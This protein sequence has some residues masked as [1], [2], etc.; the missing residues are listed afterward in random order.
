MPLVSVTMQP[1]NLPID[2]APE[3]DVDDGALDDGALDEG[4][5]GLVADA[6]AVINKAM[7][8]SAT[9]FLVTVRTVNPPV[10]VARRWAPGRLGR[11]EGTPSTAPGLRT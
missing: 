7:A 8:P 3:P 11:L 1:S 9:A 10:G 2:E 6:H 4:E 5:L